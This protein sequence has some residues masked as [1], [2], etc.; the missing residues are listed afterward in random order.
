MTDWDEDDWDDIPDDDDDESITLP[1]PACGADVYEDA[2][3]CPVCGE[4]IIR[5]SRVWDGQ[6]AWWIGLGLL[7]IAAVVLVLLLV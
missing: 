6:P 7:G 1:C 5:S 3:V 2:D 4:F